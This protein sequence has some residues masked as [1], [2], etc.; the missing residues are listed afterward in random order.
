MAIVSDAEDS[1]LNACYAISPPVMVIKYS[2]FR[3]DDGSIGVVPNIILDTSKIEREIKPPK[4][5]DDHFKNKEN[6]RPIYDKMIGKL[7]DAHPNIKPK[8]TQYYINVYTRDGGR[9]FLGVWVTKSH[10]VLN[11]RGTVKSDRFRVWGSDTAWGRAGEGGNVNVRNESEV[12]EKL[13]GWINKAY[14][15]VEKMS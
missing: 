7:R 9:G 13:L 4:S 2:L 3:Y 6:V 10:L 1:V 8:P 11:F 12:D 15:T 5:I 14:E